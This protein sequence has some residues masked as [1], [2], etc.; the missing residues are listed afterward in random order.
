MRETWHVCSW[1]A[2]TVRMGVALYT[3]VSLETTE[4]RLVNR[5]IRSVN[6]RVALYVNKSFVVYLKVSVIT[7]CCISCTVEQFLRN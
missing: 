6:Q 4:S 5:I 3:D 7:S 2:D 1:L